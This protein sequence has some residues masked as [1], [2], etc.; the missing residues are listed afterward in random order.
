MYMYI[1]IYFFCLQWHT[2]RAYGLLHNILETEIKCNL[3]IIFIA[4]LEEA[5]QVLT[6]TGQEYCYTVYFRQKIEYRWERAA[7]HFFLFNVSYTLS[8][9]WPLKRVIFVEISW[10]T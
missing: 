7:A 8:I 4:S 6:T 5:A 10:L 9:V 1:Y 2:R 3:K